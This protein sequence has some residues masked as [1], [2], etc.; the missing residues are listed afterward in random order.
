MKIQ[1][2]RN[3]VFDYCLMKN[4]YQNLCVRC[5][6]PRI[7]VR[8]WEEKLEFTTVTNTE[9]ACPD[10]ECQKMVDAENKKQMDRYTQMKRRTAE[11]MK[12][13]VRGRKRKKATV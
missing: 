7:V 13:M 2:Q 3:T 1:T 11:R 9:M 5:G 10:P 6:K 4:G 8:T 12:K